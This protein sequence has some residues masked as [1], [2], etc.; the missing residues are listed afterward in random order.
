MV[1]HFFNIII[2]PLCCFSRLLICCFIYFVLLESA[3]KQF[4]AV[5][6]GRQVYFSYFDSTI[7]EMLRIFTKN[8]ITYLWHTREATAIS[9]KNNE[10]HMQELEIKHSCCEILHPRPIFS[11]GWAIFDLSGS[12]KS[13]QY[14]FIFLQTISQSTKYVVCYV[15]SYY[16]RINRN[17]SS[18]I[19]NAQFDN[20]LYIV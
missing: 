7:T 1:D 10:Q 2:N 15:Y 17:H 3:V 4:V 12:K 8:K 11:W 13:W 20:G 19:K 14:F 5:H 9:D 6:S 18:V 16:L